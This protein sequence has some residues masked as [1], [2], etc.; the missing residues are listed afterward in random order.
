VFGNP[1]QD[2]TPLGNSTENIELSRLVMRM[3][4]SFAHDLDPNGHGGESIYE[5]LYICTVIGY[6]LI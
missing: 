1:E 6:R 2:L 5:S 4:T 3:W